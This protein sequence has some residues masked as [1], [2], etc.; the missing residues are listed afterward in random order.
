M[1]TEDLRG[2][3][4][5]ST[6]R[7]LDELDPETGRIK[8]FTT[9]DGLAAGEFLSAYR[10]QSGTLWFGTLKGLSRFTP[11][12]T[13]TAVSSP[14]VLL[15]GLRV[16]GSSST[17]SA[18]GDENIA[19]ADLPASQNQLQ[20]EFTGLNFAPGEVLRYQ[21]KLEGTSAGW[22]AAADLR[23]VTFAN[24]APGQYKIS[25]ASRQF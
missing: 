6:G 1:I 18:I 15:T 2:E 12:P 16:A 21:Y 14:P 3:I 11:P 7:G 24:L 5:V 22:S 20:I 8:H 25:G 4:Y 19:L 23:S 9:A 17:I 10:D 13:D